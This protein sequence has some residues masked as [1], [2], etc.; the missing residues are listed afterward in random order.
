MLV[1]LMSIGVCLSVLAY[2]L[3]PAPSDPQRRT[4]VI[5]DLKS[6]FGNREFIGL[7]VLA[8]LMVGPL[9]G[10]ADVWGAQFLKKNYELDAGIAASL[11][12]LIFLGMCFGGPILCYLAERK[13]RHLEV[14]L[15]SAFVMAI[16][17]SAM[18]LTRLNTSLLAG[19]FLIVGMCCA[20]Q[21][22]IIYK[23]S[24]LVGSGLVGIAS[25]AANMIIMIFGY[26]FHSSIGQIVGRFGG[27]ENTKSLSIGIM[28]IPISL[29]VSAFGLTF[30]L[31][32]KRFRIKKLAGMPIHPKA[33]CGP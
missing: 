20:Y 22:L 18:L 14:V 21:I 29:S 16:I 2:L 33:L 4:S 23:V 12:S 19:L 1:S 3:I 17:F 30:Y 15:G 13:N 5:S 9:E 25:S 7:C 6:V 31:F 11:P 8:G 32:F 24:T 26:V 10:F 28:I 27:Y